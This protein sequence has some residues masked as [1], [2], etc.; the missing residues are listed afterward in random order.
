M[1]IKTL[2]FAIG[3]TLFSFFANA[4][5]VKLNAANKK[6]ENNA[7][8]DAIEIYE[9]VAEKGYKDEKM[10]QKLGNAYYFNA[11]LA[12]AARWYTELY[13]MNDNQEPEF[14]YRYSQ[15]L[16]AIVDY[17]NADKMLVLFNMKSGNDQR[18]FL[19]KNHRNYRE[20][21]K[22][23]SGRYNIIDAGINT[24]FS[25]YGSAFFGDTLVFSSARIRGADSK[26]KLRYT[27]QL[28][29]NLYKVVQ[30][31][32]GSYSK[33]QKFSDNVN[34]N[35]NESTPI[36]TKDGKTMY[37]TR[38]NYLDGK[39]GSDTNNVTLLK[40]YKATLLNGKWT[41]IVELPFN[42]NQYSVGHPAL[43]LDNK[44]LYF[45]SNMP[46]TFGQSDLYKVIVEDNGGYSIPENLGATINTEGR[47]TFPFIS[48]DNEL[49]FSSDGRPGLGGLDIYVVKMNNENR[50]DEI[51]NVGSPV[52]GSQDDFSFIIDAKS[53][54]GFFSSNRDGG[55]GS[56]D[57]YKLTEVREIIVKQNIS[58]II[59]DQD[60]KSSLSNTK[61]SLYDE[62]F[63]FL[64]ESSTDYYG[65]YSFDI[66]CGKK[67]YLRAE[68]ESFETKEIEVIIDKNCDDV[69]YDLA[70]EKRIKLLSVGTDLANILDIPVIYFPLN[71]ADIQKDAAFQ[72]EK[73]LI[74]MNQFPSMKINVFS[75]T[76]SRHSVSYNLVLSKKRAKSTV[77]W[78]VKN[79]INANRIIGE[80]FGESKLINNCVDG[81]QC[82]ED[83]H[84]KNRRSEFI[85]INF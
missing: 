71:R 8:V 26:K 30:M 20:E 33:A 76:D 65:R 19:F 44:V 85:I 25:D 53:K 79:G 73:V 22:N 27:N 69:V 12:T 17:T 9:K 48:A 13:T 60:S 66:L 2:H 24:E 38:N 56:D 78:L 67:Y 42:S 46:G 52:N 68:M 83:E 70:L 37:F 5:I 15:S 74:I 63:I 49:Y 61:V 77:D 11:E 81:V 50:Y 1:K 58:G 80:G 64:K 84:L 31:P 7:F 72:L 4:Q 23:N 54:N 29:T 51:K 36:F 59:T 47:E 43:S 32:G 39:L 62:N 3:L 41:N 18:A 55:N 14:Y 34:T 10:F 16:K 82:S 75:H 57:I 28:A 40:L 6:Y 35:F 21:I 45:V